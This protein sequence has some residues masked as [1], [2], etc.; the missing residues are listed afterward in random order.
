MQ[1]LTIFNYEEKQIRTIMINGEPWFVLR[2]VCDTLEVNNSSDVAARL[3]EDEKG[4]DIIDT[5]GG[6]QEL[7]IISESGLYSTILI[8]RKPEAK[9]FK[10]WITHD[11][12]PAI[13]KT[14][15]YS[16][17]QYNLPKDYLSAL[18][19]L[20]ASEETKQQLLEQNQK[21]EET[22]AI[23]APKAEFFD[24]V[25]NSKTA[26]DMSKAAKVLNMGIGRNDLFAFLRDEKVLMSDN[27]P[28][29]TYVDRGYFR[30]VEQKYAKPDG[31]VHISIKTLVYQRGLEFIRKLYTG[32]ADTFKVVK[33]T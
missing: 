31:S 6:K 9:K 19:A 28:Y 3:D 8:S 23:L 25:A 12:I 11:V 7:T 26:I 33:A 29:Q 20:V 13:R 16:V 5:L 4:V 2:D 1:E 18:K 22:I 10:R 21:H 27:V 14:G 24:S 15:S 32:T 17:E 30:P